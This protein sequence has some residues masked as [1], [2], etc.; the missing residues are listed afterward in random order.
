MFVTFYNS[1]WG[2]QP[3]IYVSLSCISFVGNSLAYTPFPAFA[4][5]GS[6]SVE[7]LFFVLSI[8][9]LKSPVN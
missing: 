7:L 6:P 1:L 2:Q 5:V 3:V 4:V 8:R 9:K